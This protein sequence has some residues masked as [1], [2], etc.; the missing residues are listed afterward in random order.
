VTAR[1]P[2]GLV[3]PIAGLTVPQAAGVPLR[4]NITGT[5]AIPPPVEFRSV[6]LMVEVLSPSA[7]IEDGLAVT[8]TMIPTG[9]GLKVWVT[10]AEARLPEA[11]SV[12]V[13]VQKPG[14]VD[15]VYCPVT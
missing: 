13:M 1:P 12:A 14:V 2:F 8:V 9:T 5:P 6:A 7:R 15:A 11:A 10:V 3:T 4:V